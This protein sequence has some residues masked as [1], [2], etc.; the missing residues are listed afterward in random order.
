M[1]ED[2]KIWIFIGGVIIL[3]LVLLVVKS[4][5]KKETGK[6][7]EIVQEQK[8]EEFVSVLSDGTKVNNSNKLAETK[9][10]DELEVS[11]IRLTQKDNISKILATV[12]NPTSQVK[13]G[14]L[15]KIELLD[16][17]QKTIEEI[18]AYIDKVQPGETVT[19]NAAATVDFANAYDF[20]RTK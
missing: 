4:N 11:D 7:E 3:I 2:K 1:K 8:A 5:S 6:Q 15:V 16:K 13:G 14:Y 18:K 20:K 10:I 19:L 17:E 12:K 9:I